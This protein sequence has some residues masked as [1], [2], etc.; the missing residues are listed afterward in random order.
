M[1]KGIEWKVTICF[2]ATCTFSS[3]SFQTIRLK[4]GSPIMSLSLSRT[5]SWKKPIYGEE[6]SFLAWLST[7]AI[8]L[9]NSSNVADTWYRKKFL[10]FSFRLL[11]KKSLSLL[12]LTLLCAVNS[13]VFTLF[14]LHRTISFCSIS[15]FT[16]KKYS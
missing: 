2:S 15:K 7:Y 6:L 11:L 10:Q 1:I 8:L 3:G 9:E 12:L 14:L 5:T 4:T 13:S 16:I